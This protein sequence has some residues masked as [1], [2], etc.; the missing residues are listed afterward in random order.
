MA[1]RKVEKSKPRK[2]SGVLKN[3]SKPKA[4]GKLSRKKSGLF[5]DTGK[6]EKISQRKGKDKYTVNWKRKRRTKVE[7]ENVIRQI[8]YKK[9]VKAFP[10]TEFVNITLIGE[11]KGKKIARTYKASTQVFT[12][13][14]IENFLFEFTEDVFKHRLDYGAKKSNQWQNYLDSIVFDEFKQNEPKRIRRKNKTNT[15]KAGNRKRKT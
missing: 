8:D 7:T 9:I 5:F 3:L 15:G 12:E 1:K 10:K 11:F 2:K 13:S 4:K 14:G 6:K